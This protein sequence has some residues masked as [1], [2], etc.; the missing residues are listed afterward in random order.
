MKKKSFL[1]GALCGALAML[2][3][4]GLIFCGGKLNN[5]RRKNP[6]E[7]VEQKLGELE[8]LIDESYIHKVDEQELTEGIYKGYI[9]GLQD[10][11]TTIKRRRKK[12][13]RR[14][15]ESL[16]ELECL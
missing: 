2:L 15:P 8:S 13:M 9:A 4:A 6:A 10:L 16:R 5:D 14:L 1:Q 3:A 11:L 7:A 12:C